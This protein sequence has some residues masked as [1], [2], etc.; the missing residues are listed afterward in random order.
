MKTKLLLGLCCVLMFAQIG[1]ANDK[2]GVVDIQ[3]I[4][5]NSSEV[6]ALKNERSA[7]MEALNKIVTDAQNAIAK[8]NDPQKIIQ[9]QDKYTNEFNNKKDAIDRQY[10]QRLSSIEER[11][12]CQIADSAK[13]NNYDYVFAKSV[14]F[15]GGD[16][17]T[18]LISG[19]IR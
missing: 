3:C 18:Q 2:I 17:I 9:L 13:R 15:L 19:D 4:V 1:F 12:K 8:E 16:D 11:L 7:Q 10:S 14:V 5:N 6:K